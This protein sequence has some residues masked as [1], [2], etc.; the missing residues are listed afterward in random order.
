MSDA[1]ATTLDRIGPAPKEPTGPLRRLWELVL[2]MALTEYRRRYAGSVL[3]YAWT[4]LRPLMLFAVL[5]TVFTRVIR[6]GGS[7]PDYAV[8]LLFNIVLFSFFQEGTTAALRSYVARGSIMRSLKVPALAAPLSA[9]LAA[10]FT[11]AASIA[12][13]LTWILAYGVAPTWSWLL[14]PVLVAYL[15][16]ITV[17]VGVFLSVLFVHFRDAGQAWQPIARLLFYASPVLFPF[18]YIPEGILRSLASVNP[19]SPM[20]V[21]ARHWIIDPSAPSWTEATSNGFQTAVPFVVTLALCALAVVSYRRTRTRI[22][23]RL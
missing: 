15:A 21:E 16:V 3:G 13:A 12:I 17:A 18:D 9:I 10:S 2:I 7:V 8:M 22:A 19:L 6:F 20:F 1:A 23:E 14:L 5:Y 11:F 4:L